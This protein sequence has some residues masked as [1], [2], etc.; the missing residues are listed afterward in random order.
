M[1]ALLRA[2]VEVLPVGDPQLPVDQ[3]DAGDLLGDGMLDLDPAVQLQEEE[4]A[5]VEHELY[6]AGADVADGAGE[7][8]RSVAELAA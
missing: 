5:A 1:P 3:V 7:A 4:R 6:G 8:N 2:H